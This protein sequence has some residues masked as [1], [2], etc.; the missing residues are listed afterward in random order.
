MRNNELSAWTLLVAS[1]VLGSVTMLSLSGCK[2]PETTEV[3]VS[4]GEYV[5]SN[6]TA[7]D[8]NVTTTIS[9]AVETPIPSDNAASDN[10][11]SD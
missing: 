1:A 9:Q 4:T 8:S 6:T 5:E 11:A 2:P 3:D 7:S 10:A